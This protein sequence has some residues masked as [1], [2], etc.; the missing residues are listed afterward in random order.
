MPKKNAIYQ[1]GDKLCY[2][3]AEEENVSVKSRW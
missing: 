1:N 2:K 3:S